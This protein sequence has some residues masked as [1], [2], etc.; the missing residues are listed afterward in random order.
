MDMP[1]KAENAYRLC[2]INHA[3]LHYENA[4]ENSDKIYV[5][6]AVEVNVDH[7]T[8]YGVRFAYGRRGSRLKAGWKSRVTP[9]VTSN[10]NSRYQF[11]DNAFLMNRGTALDIFRSL[12]Q[13][14]INREYTDSSPRPVSWTPPPWLSAGND[15]AAKP[16]KEPNPVPVPKPE[17]EKPGPN[18]AEIEAIYAR[19]FELGTGEDKNQA[20]EDLL[21]TRIAE[22]SK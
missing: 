9:R 15:N 13:E 2:V 8:G 22:L 12:R 21:N 3:T 17:P 16:R 20:E 6:E 5:V 18:D 10:S 11:Y 4:R 1:E 19:L 7:G 14:K